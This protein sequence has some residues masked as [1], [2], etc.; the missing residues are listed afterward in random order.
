MTI[1]SLVPPSVQASNS[2]NHLD[3]MYLEFCLSAK[4]RSIDLRFDA[5]GSQLVNLLAFSSK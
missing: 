5:F 4:R 3:M 2:P 1:L